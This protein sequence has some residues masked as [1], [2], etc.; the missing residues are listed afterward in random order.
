M[1]STLHAPSRAVALVLMVIAPALWSI[2]GVLT[3]QTESAPPFELVFWRSVFAGLFVAA[4]LAAWQGTGAIRALRATGW[5]GVLSGLMWAAMFTCF[6]LALTLTT[7]AG[8]LVTMS[9]APLFTALLAWRVLREPVA[10][11]TWIAIGVAALGM[12]VMFSEGL[13]QGDQR[14]L[15][16]TLVA[17][18]VPIASAINVTILRRTAARVDLIP[19]I[20][21][22]AL[23]SAL[24]CLPLI[25]PFSASASDIVILA[26]LGIFQLGLPCV[27]YVIASR[28]LLAPELALLALIEVLLGPLWAWWGAGEVPG[29]ETLIGGALVLAALAG[30]QLAAYQQSRNSTTA[31]I[32]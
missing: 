3:R 22:G 24:I 11:R 1:T 15:L 4:T 26:V 27:L 2:A 5:A 14:A 17:L 31:R 25:L 23:L 6:M 10:P 13:T 8:T 9:L 12:T 7:T 29:G 32:T 16:G 28:T 21:I 19:A 20:L 18:C 30:N